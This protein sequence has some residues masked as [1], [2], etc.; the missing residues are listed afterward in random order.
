MGEGA[1][2]AVTTDAIALTRYCIHS[3]MVM[4][5]WTGLAPW[6]FEFPVPG[7]LILTFLVHLERSTCD[8]ISGRGDYRGT[9]LIKKRTLVA[10]YSRTIP[11]DL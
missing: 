10:P 6:K 7:S 3:I 1:H 9:S 11:R 5:W 4:I 8:A 2:F